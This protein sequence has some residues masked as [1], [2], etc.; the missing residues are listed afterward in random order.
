MFFLFY[1]FVPC[2]NFCRSCFQHVCSMLRVH[3]DPHLTVLTPNHQLT[4]AFR[5]RSKSSSEKWSWTGTPPIV[6]NNHSCWSWYII[7]IYIYHDHFL[8]RLLFIFSSGKKMSIGKIMR[9]RTESSTNSLHQEGFVFTMAHG[10]LPIGFQPCHF[11]AFWVVPHGTWQTYIPAI[12]Q[13]APTEV[14][15]IHV[16]CGKALKLTVR[17]EKSR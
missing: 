12:S 16:Q 14:Y 1:E 4:R 9:S 8:K 7:Y 17:S 3:G 11:G 10:P 13:S 6:S 5:D 15:I 2:T